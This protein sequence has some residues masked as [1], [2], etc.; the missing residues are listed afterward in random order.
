MGAWFKNGVEV[1]WTSRVGALRVLREAEPSKE[2]PMVRCNTVEFVI[3]R[4]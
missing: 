1:A 4:R 3:N 2:R